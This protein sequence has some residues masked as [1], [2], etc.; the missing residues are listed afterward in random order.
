MSQR[1]VPQDLLLHKICIEILEIDNCIR[2]AG[3][4]NNMG[5]ITAAQYRGELGPA[6]KQSGCSFLTKEELELSAIESVLRMVTRKDMISKL[7]KP[8]YSFTLY[9]NV[10][11][12]TISLENNNNHILMASFDNNKGSNQESIILNGILPLVSY[13]LSRAQTLS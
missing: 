6:E 13:Y 11:R 2:F 5:K 8:I 1:L 3:F 10:K 12:A 7:G 9:E 4:A